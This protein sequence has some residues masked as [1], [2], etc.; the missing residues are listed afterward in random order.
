MPQLNWS[1]RI[2][3]TDAG[4]AAFQPQLSPAVPPGTPLQ[5]QTQDIVTWGNQTT[6]PHQPWLANADGTPVEPA[7]TQSDPTPAGFI[8]EVISAGG[9]S[10]PQF[11]VPAGT[12]GTVIRYC[13][14]L[15]PNDP[16]EQGQIVLA[17]FS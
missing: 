12:V 9:S 13:C 11:V 14:L 2:V 7:P 10:T 4:G 1:I 3:P 6:Q 8:C 5:A 16:T 17:N 15:H